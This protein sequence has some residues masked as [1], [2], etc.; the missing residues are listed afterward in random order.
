MRT[1]YSILILVFLPCFLLAQDTLY[2][3]NGSMQLVDV[4]EIKPNAIRYHD[5]P[6]TGTTHIISTEAIEKIAFR[7]GSVKTFI[8]AAAEELPTAVNVNNGSNTYGRNFISMNVLDVGTNH[9]TLG[10]EHTLKSG[11]WSL[12]IPLSIKLSQQDAIM[13]Y[14]ANTNK[15]KEFRT[16]IEFYYYP[17]NQTKARF[18]YGPAFEYGTQRLLFQTYT[19]G[20]ELHPA[21][22]TYYAA[23][24]QCGYLF[25]PDK[26]FNFSISTGL[27]YTNSTIQQ[28]ADFYHSFTNENHLATRLEVNLGY[29]F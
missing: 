17:Y 19:N 2:R 4:L 26:H 20:Y 28:Y 6:S 3:A 1:T 25:Q 10:F 29:R 5:A 7:N 11:K 13:S 16:G 15:Q 18:F 24:L 8:H 9:F 21:N 23:L 22:T 14:K 27:G 12:R